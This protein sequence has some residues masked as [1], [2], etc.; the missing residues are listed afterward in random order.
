MFA[1]LGINSSCFYQIAGH[2]GVKH[3]PVRLSH[4][5]INSEAYIDIQKR[6]SACPK[7]LNLKKICHYSPCTT[8]YQTLCSYVLQQNL[9]VQNTNSLCSK[10][11]INASQN[12]MFSRS[13]LSSILNAM[14]VFPKKDPDLLMMMIITI[15]SR[16]Q[17][18]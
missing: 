16:C 17:D 9:C 1:E 14:L 18:V 10:S 6:P 4:H 13:P 15:K 12:Q 5:N 7:A 2:C 8:K 11:L 3:C